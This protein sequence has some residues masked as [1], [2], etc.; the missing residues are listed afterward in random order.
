MPCRRS[1]VR[2]PSAAS[3][4]AWHFQAFFACAVGL[5]VWSVGLIRTRGGPI[6][7]SRNGFAGRF[8][9]SEPKSFCG[10]AE[11]QVFGLLR[12]LLT[13]PAA[14]ARICG[15]RPA[16][17]LPATPV[18]GS[19]SGFSPETARST[20]LRAAT[21]LAMVPSAVS[22][23]AERHPRQRRGPITGSQCRGSTR[24]SSPRVSLSIG[25]Q[26][27]ARAPGLARWLSS[28]A[29]VGGVAAETS[30]FIRWMAG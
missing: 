17:A 19:Q 27:S 25:E 6:A 4:K 28:G 16:G 2:I 1:W 15:Q 10:P 29:G 12:P 9:S 23:S 18:L 3:E 7:A 20:S 21:R 8:G 11:G 5:C 30:P 14:T 22:F 26:A 24:G 13:T